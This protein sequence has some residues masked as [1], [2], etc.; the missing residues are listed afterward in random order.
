MKQKN[1]VRKPRPRTPAAA[2]PPAHVPVEVTNCHFLGDATSVLFSQK[3]NLA[4]AQIES[5]K[6]VVYASPAFLSV[7]DAIIISGS[8]RREY[9]RREALGKAAKAVAKAALGWLS[10]FLED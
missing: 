7:R 2:A 3:T 9:L 5:R 6:S 1:P 4:E 8:H 10:T